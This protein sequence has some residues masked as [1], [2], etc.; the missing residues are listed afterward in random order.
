MFIRATPIRPKTTG[1]HYYTHSLVESVRV[2]SKVTQVLLLNLGRHFPIDKAYW[3]ALAKRIEEI[4]R[5]QAPLIPIHLPPLLEREAQ[6]IVAT[7]HARA[8]RPTDTATATPPPAVAPPPAESA[9]ERDLQTVD[10]ASLELLRPRSVGVEH[11]GLWAMGQ[12]DFI[13]LLTGLGLSGPQR[14]AVVGSIIARMAEPASELASWR[15][16]HHESGLGELLDFDL[17]QRLSLKSLYQA[18]DLLM[19][20]RSTIEAALF[21]RTIDLFGLEPS[22][23]LYDLT[24]TYFEGNQLANPKGQRGRSK[25]KRTDRPLVTLGMVLDGSGFTRRSETF[26]GNVSEPR[27]LER[28]LQGLGATA[29]SL[30]VLDAGIATEENLAWLR[31]Q[32]YRYLAVSRERMRQFHP[33][34]A[35]PLL[36]AGGA[37]VRIERVNDA[38]GEEVRLYCHSADRQGKEEG[39]STRFCQRFEAGLQA[40]ADGLA[41]PRAEKRMTRLHERIGRLKEKSRGVGQHYTIELIPDETGER[42]VDLRWEKRPQAGTMLT[43][44]GVY[45]LRTNQ[46]DWDSERLWRT[47]T[48]LT[49]LEAVFRSLKSELGLRPVFHHQEGRVEGHLFITVLAYQFVQIIRRRLHEQGIADSWTRLRDTARIQR[50][51]TASF[52]RADG[53]RLHVRKATQPEPE[54]RAIYAALGLNPIPGHLEKTIA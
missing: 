47:Y 54:L 14:A 19:R 50:R 43:H 17:E 20:H 38:E 34:A 44:P 48:L 3:P 31:A 15:W 25:E 11:L 9:P 27:T 16:L 8:G 42:A 37:T 33:E 26:E 13:G 51:I 12:V 39:I 21:N 4:Y 36:T 53:R 32:G 41:K 29:G 45:C 46:T 18:S 1:E 22:I 6:R 28:M 49:D 5:A 40:L 23:V 30:V 10:V 2:G 52:E 24:N 35:L 7:L